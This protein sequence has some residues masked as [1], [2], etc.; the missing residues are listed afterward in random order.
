MAATEA[1]IIDPHGD[2]ILQVENERLLVS[3]RVLSLVSP[4]FEAMLK[5]NFK[6]GIAFRMAKGE[7]FTIPLPE[8]DMEGLTLF[9]KT[10]H[11]Q[12][13]IAPNPLCLEKLAVICDKY[14]CTGPMKVYG[15][16]W[17]QMLPGEIEEYSS[18]DVGR[19]LLFAYVLDLAREFSAL[20]AELIHREEWLFDELPG[21][22]DHPLMCHELP[23]K[24]F[25]IR[26]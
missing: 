5:P 4:V 14:Q 23:G 16:V 21:V 8:D 25:C 12:A 19:L 20:A 6:E 7:P 17:L 1:T 18:E 15:T 10:I 9:C 2:L 24:T 11:H 13:P 3:S 26:F 22:A